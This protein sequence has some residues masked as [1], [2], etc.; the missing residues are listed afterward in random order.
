MYILDENFVNISAYDVHLAQ[1]FISK[2]Q[3]SNDFN[4]I[5]QRIELYK[6]D[7]TVSD[8][9]FIKI[10]QHDPIVNYILEMYKGELNLQM[11][12]NSIMWSIMNIRN[13]KKFEIE[14]LYKN[15]ML[16]RLHSNEPWT[17]EKENK[18]IIEFLNDNKE[19]YAYI[20]CTQSIDECIENDERKLEVQKKLEKNLNK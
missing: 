5:N 20:I 18:T 11:L 12:A 4:Q 8:K 14:N 16:E 10:N 3:N 6:Q 2:D 13:D 17:S 9:K 15:V 19:L 7:L 1:K